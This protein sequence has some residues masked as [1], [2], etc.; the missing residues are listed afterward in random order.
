MIV[1][2]PVD[3]RRLFP[4]EAAASLPI[5]ARVKAR[6]NSGRLTDDDLRLY[7]SLGAMPEKD[8]PDAVNSVYA[9]GW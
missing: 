1:D 7:I 4:H 2:L 9:Q 6:T 8:D 3:R 5:Q